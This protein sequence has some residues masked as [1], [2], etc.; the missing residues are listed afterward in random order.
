MENDDGFIQVPDKHALQRNNRYVMLTSRV[1][2]CEGEKDQYCRE[3]LIIF[4]T[5]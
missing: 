3:M 5:V 4:N 1:C 2:A